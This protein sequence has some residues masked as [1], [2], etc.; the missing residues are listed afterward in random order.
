MGKVL[1]T[2]ADV[3]GMTGNNEDEL[4]SEFLGPDP[5]KKPS[6]FDEPYVEAFDIGPE[7]N[8]VSEEKLKKV[9]SS[10]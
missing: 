6:V 1:S 5:D 10:T 7:N 3:L 2:V 4:E 8:G 9:I